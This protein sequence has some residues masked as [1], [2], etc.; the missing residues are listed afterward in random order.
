MPGIRCGTVHLLLMASFFIAILFPLDRP[1]PYTNLITVKSIAVASFGAKPDDAVND[2]P[3]VEAAITAARNAGVPV[4]IR[5][6]PGRYIFDCEP[7]NRA[8]LELSNMNN[9]VVSGNGAEIIMKHP[10]VSFLK[11]RYATN[12]IVK[13][14]VVDWDPLPFTQGIV[15]AVDAVNSTFDLHLDAGFPSLKEPYF[16]R[17]SFGMLKDKNIPGRMK[18]AVDDFFQNEGFSNVAPD[19]YR[20]RLKRKDV[21]R[22]FAVGDRF[23]QYARI[24]SLSGTYSSENVSFIGITNYSSPGANYVASQSSRLSFLSCAVLLKP[25]RWASS[26]ADGVHVQQ[27]RIGPWVEDCV[28]EGIADDGVNFYTIPSYPVSNE[29]GTLSVTRQ[30]SMVVGDVLR[31]F[32]PRQG[33]LVHEAKIVTLVNS[34]GLFALV[35]D[36]VVTSS[37]TF[38]RSKDADHVYNMNAMSSHFVIRNN[39]F[40]NSR[41]Y[42]NY[43]KT[44][45]GIIEG[46]VYEGLG[47]TAIIMANEP[48]WPE[49]FVAERIVVRNNVIRDCGIDGNTPRRGGGIWI[50]THMLGGK[51]GAWRGMRDIII[52]SNAIIRPLSMAINI[53]SASNVTIE[54]N[55]IEM[56]AKWPE[57]RGSTNVAVRI[58]NTSAVTFIGNTIR[59]TR[60]DIPWLATNDCDVF[61]ERNNRI[62]K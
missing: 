21:I 15:E 56:A 54:N 11:I 12:I 36:P 28:F 35:L 48:D 20:F 57:A 9:L 29:N 31:I 30:Q 46:N 62:E 47:S 27:N 53:H 14:F 55:I 41:R 6:E 32:N 13:H 60:G 34:N 59:E 3:A 61:V 16:A 7:T 50:D 18:A 58:T 40:R 10:E 5:F 19:I 45:D 39:I 4:E 49:G 25:G 52:A 2:L 26:A 38:G 24:A 44:H 8:A 37:L 23:V 17:P 51:T 22:A 43:I 42:G 1:P 33:L